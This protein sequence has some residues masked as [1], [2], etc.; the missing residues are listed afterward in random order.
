MAGMPKGRSWVASEPRASSSK[1]FVSA[2]P[3][4][5]NKSSRS[6]A[7]ATKCCTSSLEEPGAGFCRGRSASV[8]PWRFRRQDS[9][10]RQWRLVRSRTRDSPLRSIGTLRRPPPIRIQKWLG[11]KH[12]I[13]RGRKRRHPGRIVQ[14]QSTLVCA[15]PVIPAPTA[16]TETSEAF[17]AGWAA[18]TRPER[19]G[20]G[21]TFPWRGLLALRRIGR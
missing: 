9:S 7:P 6:L 11:T 20:W 1:L 8:R 5:P 15:T 12:Q 21:L 10:R 14:S 19:E 16:L 17:A 13:D 2:P 3:N 4:S 18:A